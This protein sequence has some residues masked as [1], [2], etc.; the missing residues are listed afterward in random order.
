LP[1]AGFLGKGLTFWASYF[2]T[3]DFLGKSDLLGKAQPFNLSA[4]P[5][6]AVF[7]LTSMGR[8][9]F[10]PDFLGKRLTFCARFVYE[11]LNL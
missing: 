6:K 10:G 2:S 3:G 11:E 7:E 4:L 9:I 8:L 5:N 1:L